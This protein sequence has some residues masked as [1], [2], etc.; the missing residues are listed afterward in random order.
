MITLLLALFIVLWSISSVNTSKFSALRESLQQA[1]NGKIVTGSESIL[2]G[3]SNPLNPQGTQV[4]TI[5]PTPTPSPTS[6]TD[7]LK[8]QIITATGKADLDNLKRIRQNIEAYAHAH[9]LSG[10]LHTSI[11]ERGLVIRLL[12]DQLLFDSGSAVLK[13]GS[14]PLLAHISKALVSGGT[15]NPVRVEGNTD[16]QPITTSA[17]PSNWDLSSARADAVVRYLIA[18]GLGAKRLS[19]TGYADQRPIASNATAAGRAANRRV[20]LVVLRRSSQ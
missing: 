5:Q 13:T 15:T 1:F 11:N 3:G 18:T 4:Q 16:N 2:P 20:E 17:F 19:V 6:I 10:V 12:T 9:G 14:E 8:A 7:T